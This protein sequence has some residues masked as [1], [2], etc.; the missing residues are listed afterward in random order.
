M[1]GNPLGALFGSGDTETPETKT[2][3]PTPMSVDSGDDKTTGA[4]DAAS[5][6]KK[7]RG[8]ASTRTAVNTALSSADSTGK[9]TLG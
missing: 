5:K 7:K 3:D 4:A 8:F 1:C 2:V 6:A 9:S